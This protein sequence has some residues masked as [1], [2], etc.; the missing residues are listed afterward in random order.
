MSIKNAVKLNI[1]LVCFFLICILYSNYYV[2]KKIETNNKY[3]NS[4]SELIFTQ[5]M[6]NTSILDVTS[7]QRLLQLGR[8]KN[9]FENDT[10][11]F[12]SLF[13]SLN[14]PTNTEEIAF[15]NGTFI[16][17]IFEDLKKLIVHKNDGELSFSVLY[18]LQKNKINLKKTLERNLP[19]EKKLRKSI[20][21]KVLKQ[22]DI[23]I[24]KNFTT[25]EY[26]SKEAL[27][28]YK[29]KKYFDKWAFE[30]KQLK[31]KIEIPEI[32]EYLQIISRLSINIFELNEIEKME[33]VMSQNITDIRQS[34]KQLNRKISSDVE[35]IT[36]E[37]THDLNYMLLALI[38]F[39]LLIV[40]VLG[41]KIYNNIGLSVD[42]ANAKIEFET[43]ENR[44]KDELLSHQSK[45]VAM[46]EMMG[47]IA[48]QWR[49]PLNALAGNVQFLREDFV[50]GIIDEKFI[51]KYVKDN[52]MLINFMSK[53][54]DDFRNFFKTDKL[55]TN[56]NIS[57]C[58]AKP[59]SILKPQLDEYHIDCDVEGDD[60]IVHDLQ[61]EFQQVILNIVN[62]AKD[63]LLE[64]K[65]KNPKIQIKTYKKYSNGFIIIEDNAGG[66]PPA[67]INRVFEPYFTTKDEGQG[68]GIG[69]FMSKMIVV[70]NMQGKISVSNSDV[71]ARFEIELKIIENQII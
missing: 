15:S 28:Q 63:A 64:N 24:F 55:K 1:A 66:I 19:V 18:E 48:H 49:Q 45:L 58:I 14:I 4:I 51:D 56:F 36:Q 31:N 26:Y 27:F 38:L 32:D 61:S 46:G 42:E 44:K 54:I 2:L 22:N 6:M 12:N 68:T 57:A 7:A 52:M 40:V 9:K 16:N 65:V 33:W 8:I 59:L 30:I 53:T 5:D 21:A 71:G 29:N 37:L 43:N 3:K 39:V 62:N 69:L 70:D 17:Q 20:K 67:V 50:D 47:N 25:A 23:S 41:L 10:E 35:R 60:F 34:N 11:N 13:K